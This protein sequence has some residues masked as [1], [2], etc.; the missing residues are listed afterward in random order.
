MEGVVSKN[1][2]LL[3]EKFAAA[4][5]FG[6]WCSAIHA[7]GTAGYAGTVAVAQDMLHYTKLRAKS[8]GKDTYM[9]KLNFYGGSYV[10]VLGATFVNLYLDRVGKMV[11]NGVVAVEDWYKGD[12][13][14]GLQQMDST[15]ETFFTSCYAAGSNCVFNK[16]ATSAAEI[17]AR[18]DAILVDL[19]KNPVSYYDPNVVQY[20]VIVTDRGLDGLIVQS[21]YSSIELFTLL[22][23]IMVS[24][25][26]RNA[27]ALVMAQRLGQMPDLK[28][29]NEQSEE[30]QA[31]K[32]LREYDNTS[33]FFII[34][35]MDAG[36]SYNISSM[37]EYRNSVNNG[38]GLS[39]YG[40]DS[41]A[42]QGPVMYCS[43]NLQTPEIQIFKGKHLSLFFT[44]S[45]LPSCPQAHTS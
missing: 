34:K 12:R 36:G 5:A 18:F 37:Q 33:A 31:S 35:C 20:P 4:N 30:K 17:K 40:G 23:V 2:A 44:L 26:Q 11:L 19:E 9:A 24:L 28:C 39:K 15:V 42:A 6:K 29:D 14:T 22:T 7:N 25:E 45:L 43:L 16:N 38:V 3:S 27:K 32:S 10:T 13:M 8:R 41:Y 1:M 21:T